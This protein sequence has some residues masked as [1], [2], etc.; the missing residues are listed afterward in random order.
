[1]NQKIKIS[2]GIKYSI[3]GLALL[4]FLMIW[5]TNIIHKTEVSKSCEKILQVSDPISVENNG[6][7]MFVAE[8]NYLDAVELYI[9]NDMAGE[10]ITFRVYDGDYKQLWE[11]FV[12]VDPETEFPGFLKIKIE[13]EVEEG[14]AYYYTVEGLTTDL[15]LY[16]EDTAT[17]ESVANGTLLY[18]G[19]EMPGINLIIRYHYT[20][21]FAWWMIL[22]FGAFLAIIAKAGCIF[23]DRLFDKQDSKKNKEITVQ[24]LIQII[25]NP[26]VAV[27]TLVLLFMV[28]PKKSF[29]FGAL[30]YGF[31]YIGIAIAA[32]VLLLGINY[33]RKGMEP[34]LSLET[35]KKDWPL[36]VMS[37]SFA[38]VLWSCYQYL[39]GL[40][41]IHHMYASCKM[42]TWFCV[43]LLCTFG[44][45][46]LWKLYNLVYV[47]AA[48]FWREEY[49]KPYLGVNEKEELY[50]LQSLVIIFGVFVGIQ[51][52]LSIIRMLRK[53]EK[54]TAK[55]CYPYAALIAAWMILMLVYRNGREWIVLMAVMFAI[56]YYCMW[57]WERRNEL[58]HVFCNGIIFNFIY[59]V[60]YCLLHR[61]YLRFRH[62]RF[63]LGFHTVTM[64]GYY[65]A[66]VIAAI[67][68]RLF[69]QY[70]KTKR[71][72][73][74]WKELSLL[75]IAN[76]YLFMTLSR[77]GYLS[78]FVMQIF[79]L[80][81]MS[82]AWN[83]KKIQSILV[84]AGLMIGASVLAFPMVF[85]AQRIVPAMV[86][87]PM[88]SEIEIWEY[89]VEK[90][91]PTD[92]ELYIDI[93]AFMKVLGNKLFGLDTGN[94]SLSKMEENVKH[95]LQKWEDRSNP[96][97]IRDDSY[98]VA[99]EAE[100]YEEED[101][102]NGRFEIFTCYIEHWNMNG[103]EDMGVPLPDGSIA[104]HAHNTYLQMIHDNGLITGAVFV[105]L[106]VVSF[107]VAMIRYSKEKREDSYLTLT[108]AIIIGFAIAGLVEWIFQ[109]N[110]FFGIAILVVVTPLLFQT[111][112]EKQK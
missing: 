31:Y 33:K 41:D 26:V 90:G 97:Y 50:K 35:V 83:K 86:N 11:T 17:S 100:S 32:A 109:I 68:V 66:F 81:W 64:T 71:W 79:M 49:I 27:V 51:I 99:S 14:W 88:Y 10:I 44:R 39:N 85:T 7:Q 78:A 95:E 75:G 62:N 20:E 34:L 42:L 4:V 70:S 56:F 72:I 58:L 46:Y 2:E 1:M 91:D 55:L 8:G 29:G 98:M 107:F 28:F 73:D 103:H 45:E 23:V 47:A 40:Y 53:K 77:T 24:Q 57:R 9:N 106:G 52:I 76:A 80:V 3:V 67:V 111:G 36:W 22:I 101:I 30:N 110:N 25:A 54:V 59:M 93:T 87:D 61:P 16:Y 102:S 112:K 37:V 104:V 74:C 48:Y 6:T 82:L 105:I 92:S 65:L 69:I 60:G 12:N 13:M 15:E 96:I 108:V 89:V 5:P 63:G 43:M 94:I 38:G 18:G 21:N 19:E 84:S